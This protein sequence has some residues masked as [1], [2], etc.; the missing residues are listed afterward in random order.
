VKILFVCLGNICRSP[1]AHGVF[2]SMVDNQGLS[3]QFVIDSA[4]TAA[5]HIGKAPDTR[6]Q[7]FAKQRAYDLSSLQAR[8]VASTDYEQFDLILA[9]DESN[10][11]KLRSACPKQHLSKLKLFLDYSECQESEVPDPYYG[12]DSGF[13]HVLDLVESAS[14]GLLRSLVKIDTETV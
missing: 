13:D 8:Q 14:E 5:W 10:L 6:S 12:G 4:G 1:T 7:Y 11:E 3:E 9:M 2:Q